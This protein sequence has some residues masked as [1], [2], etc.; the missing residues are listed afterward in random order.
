MRVNLFQSLHFKCILITYIYAICTR[1]LLSLLGESIFLGDFLKSSFGP[2][3]ALFQK[4]RVLNDLAKIAITWPFGHFWSRCLRQKVLQCFH[5]K[6]IL[7]RYIYAICTRVLL[8]LLGESIFLGDFLKSSFGPPFALFQKMRV[9]N[10]LAKI[11]ITW[12]FGHFW[13]RCLRQKVL[14]CF[15]F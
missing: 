10:D 2:P 6:C 9:L 13:S 8:S 4:M 5:F 7:I 15:H 12:P 11:A 3:F 1:V 14:Q